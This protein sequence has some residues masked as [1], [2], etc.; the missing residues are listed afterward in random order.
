MFDF[1][2][3]IIVIKCGHLAAIVSANQEA[4]RA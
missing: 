2:T 1:I 3:V 4:A